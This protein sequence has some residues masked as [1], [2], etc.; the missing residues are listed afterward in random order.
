MTADLVHELESAVFTQLHGVR[1]LCSLQLQNHIYGCY[2]LMEDI[3]MSHITHT[4]TTVSTVSHSFDYEKGFAEIGLR[5]GFLMDTKLELES[6]LPA[7]QA[8]W[9]RCFAAMGASHDLEKVDKIED[10]L[11]DTV[12]RSIEKEEGFFMNAVEHGA[13]TR[14]WID[15]VLQ[16]LRGGAGAG[17]GAGACLDTEKDITPS[18]SVL[19]HAHIE[20][21]ITHEKSRRLD[22]TRRNK[23]RQEGDAVGTPRR[24][25]IAKTR[26]HRQG[27]KK[28]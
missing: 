20:K 1:G 15:K 27:R 12:L 8:A 7:Y 22:T 17:A 9:L 19:S 6:W 28:N 21:P 23:E 10:T 3:A 14:D 16:L 5:Y 4:G 24:S 25:H 18:D 26:K 13:L 11:N 2:F